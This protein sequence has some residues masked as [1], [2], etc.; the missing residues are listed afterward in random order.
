MCMGRCSSRIGSCRLRVVW[1]GEWQS[2]PGDREILSY[3]HSEKR[4]LITLDKDFGELA[5]FHNL[6]RCGIM[7][8]VNLSSRQQPQVC[9]YAL[10]KYSAE[11]QAGAI[12]TVESG[13]IRIRESEL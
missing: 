12:V 11:L 4:V 7:R 1:V 13:R 5:V 10:E 6:P 2:D 3:A 9:L 8:L